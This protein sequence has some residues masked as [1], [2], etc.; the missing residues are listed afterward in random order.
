VEYWYDLD[1]ASAA[2]RIV[3]GTEEILGILAESG[4]LDLPEPTWPACE[5]GQP[6]CTEAY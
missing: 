4:R 2:E 1:P 6:G 3:A 5:C